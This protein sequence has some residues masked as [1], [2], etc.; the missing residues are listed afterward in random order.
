M[1]AMKDSGIEWIGD[2]PEGWKIVKLKYLLSDNLQ[3]GASESG[4]NEQIGSKR[5]IRITDIDKDGNLKN[6]N[7]LYLPD[8]IADQYKVIK[9][10]ILFARSGATVGKTYIHKI[11]EICSFAGYLIKCSINIKRFLPSLFFH[12][13]NCS[14]Y[15]DWKRQIFNQATIQN[16]SAEKL[17]N[18]LIPVSSLAE[19][20]AIANYLDKKC[21]SIDT[22]IEKEQ[23][24][25]EKLTEYKQSVIT[26][27]VTKGLNPDVPMKDSEIELIGKIP[28][29]WKLLTLGQVTDSLRNGYVGPTQNLFYDFGVPYIQ[30]LHIKEGKINFEKKHY[31]VSKDWADKHPKIYTDDILIV[32]T[33][34]IGQVG[35]VKEKFDNCNCHALIIARP[36]KNIVLARFLTYYLRS[37]SGKELMLQT[38]TGVAL[39]HLNSTKIVKTPIPLPSLSEQTAI[40]NY[41]DKKCASIDNVVAKKQQLI[42]KLTEYRKSLIYEMVTGK[43]EVPLC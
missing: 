26:E 39:P 8:N 34:D 10:D 42:D 37:E 13:T 19:Q 9:N 32:Q 14:A 35:L 17:A 3:Y 33:G 2:I 28:K 24:V 1:R 23:Q 11:S 41:L 20:T 12:F 22:V 27:A 21:A 43:K 29:E 18:L 6:E 31:F 4:F 40:A 30:S 38:K 36:S 7:I 25:I 16:I 15:E 5:Y